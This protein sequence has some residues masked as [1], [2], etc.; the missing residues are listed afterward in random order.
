MKKEAKFEY[1]WVIAAAC[2]MICFTG[3][4]FCSGNKGL[5]L[6][7]VSEALQIPRSVYAVS[8]SLRYVSTAVTNLFFGFLVQKYG[9]R[10]LV[11][12]A[13]GALALS[14]L[15]NS[16]AQSVIGIYL[17]GMLL[18]LGLT[19]GG[20]TLVGYVIKRWFRENQGTIMG[21][22]LCANALGTAVTAPW[23]SKLI[24]SGDPFGYRIAYRITSVILVVVGIVLVAL[25]RETPQQD[26][27]S[28]G[29]KKKRS[30]GNWE[31]I[32]LTQ[33]LRK[34]Y[35]YVACVSIFCTGAVLQSVT[36]VAVAHIKDQGLSAEFA[37]TISSVS[38]LSL[39]AF[40]FLTG[41]MY[42]RKGLK[43]TMLICDGAAIVMILLLSIV[44]NSVQGQVFSITYAVLAA[45]ALPLETVMLPLIAGDLFGEKEFGKLLGIFVSVNTAGYAVGPL[46][47]NLCFDMVGTYNPIFR[48]YAVVMAGVAVAFLFV[49]KQVAATR[50]AMESACEEGSLSE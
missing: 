6:A 44:T 22:V 20:T 43:T 10:K 34:P 29:N 41:F 11:G 24:Y 31:G 28:T 9:V 35:F 27:Q 8:D 7:A 32:T 49:H 36:G 45:L 15:V 37:A 26:S 40:K 25:L 1:K 3:L 47:A 42:D 4:G 23:F 39:A 17:G 12:V 33:A 21:V 50:L 18:G 46:V 16:M 30:S 38:A 19:F 48:I 14:C 13:M 2:F 5:F